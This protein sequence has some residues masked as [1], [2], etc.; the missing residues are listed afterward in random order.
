MTFKDQLKQDLSVFFNPDEFGTV[1]E[2]HLNG[3]HTN[4]PVQF[5]DEESELG[6]SRL[7]KMVFD[8]NELPNISK[9]GYFIIGSDKYGV[10]DFKPDEEE[11]LMQVILQVDGRL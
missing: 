8:I 7:R 11:L 6:D 1:V 5:F 10:V 3:N 9:N 2:Y 4:V